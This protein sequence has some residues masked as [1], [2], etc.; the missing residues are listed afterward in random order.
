MAII[1]DGHNLIGKIPDLSLEDPDDELKLIRRLHLF[2]QRTGKPITV[3]F[4]PGSHYTPPQKP[5]Y[6]DVRVIYAPQGRTADRV[7][8]ALVKKARNPREITVVTSDNALAGLVKVSGAQ[9]LR[10]EEFI[11]RMKSPAPEA[12]REEAMEEEERADIH[13]S[14]A[15]VD[16]WMAEFAKARRERRRKRSASH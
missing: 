9:V 11:Q 10:A 13:L 8:A 15:E 7:I 6:T 14:K 12:G 5:A 1:I 2:A 3:V 4:D 16:A